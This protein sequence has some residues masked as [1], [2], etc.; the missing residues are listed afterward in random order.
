[1]KRILSPAIV[2]LMLTLGAYAQTAPDA[3]E[4]TGLL[5]EFLAGASRNDAAMHDRFWAE[6]LIYTGS[7][8]RRVGK[9]D[10][11]RDVRSAPAP[12]AG[13]PTT[14]YTAEDIRIQQYGDT[15]IVAFR[16]VGATGKDG[17][18]EVTKYLNTGTFL[19]RNGKWQAVSWQATK[20]PRPEE[21]ARQEVA[22]AEAAFHQAILAADIKKLESLTDESFIWT[23]RTGEQQTRQQLLDQLGSGQLKY[24]KL[25]TSNVTVT[26][27]GDTAV[28]RGVSPQQRSAIPG[29]E[30]S[31]DPSPFTAF[32]TLTFINKGGAWKAVAMHSSRP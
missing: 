13:A 9:A 5:K 2:V 32:Y 22:A 8:G 27:Y 7:A 18:T 26:V 12:R 25:E 11:L 10:I 30:G 17:K 3:T 6:D 23:H 15:A 4:L 1:M 28:V 20:M 24:S 14:T 21:E 29:S 16:L 31:G 19:R